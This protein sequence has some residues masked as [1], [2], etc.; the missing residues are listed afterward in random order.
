MF[1]DDLAQ[2]TI[3]ETDKTK[4]RLLKSPGLLF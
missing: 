4:E 1:L 2:R 3:I